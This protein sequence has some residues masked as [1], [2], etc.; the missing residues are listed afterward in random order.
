MMPSFGSM[1][2]SSPSKNKELSIASLSITFANSTA[3]FTPSI[4]SVKVYVR[5]PHKNEELSYELS[6]S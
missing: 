3:L 2:N 5:G 4:T 1:I 6:L